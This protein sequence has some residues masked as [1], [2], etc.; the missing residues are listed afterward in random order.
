MPTSCLRAAPAIAPIA[1]VIRVIYVTF[2]TH[3][4][5]LKRRLSL[6]TLASCLTLGFTSAAA[7]TVEDDAARSAG[8]SD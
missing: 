6:L 8:A 7:Q 4:T 3:V 5:R 1:L 2:A